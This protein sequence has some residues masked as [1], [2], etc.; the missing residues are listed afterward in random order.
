MSA[1]SSSPR[2]FT[3]V[4]VLVSLFLIVLALGALEG[5]MAVTVRQL[6]NSARES[7]ATQ[8]VQKR[9]EWLIASPCATSSGNDSSR[10]VVDTWSAT[11]DGHVVWIDQE[12][13]YSTVFGEHTEAYRTAGVCQ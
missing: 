9:S 7:L 3:V 4:E 1:S 10:G 11:T 5:E 2:G 12:A 6:S 8:L 13:H